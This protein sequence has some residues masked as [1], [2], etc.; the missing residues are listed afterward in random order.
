MGVVVAFDYDAW[1]ARYPEFTSVTEPVAE[2][3]FAEACVY[4]AN[5]G[6][7]PVNN[8][9]VQ[10]ALLGMLTAHIAARYQNQKANNPVG[11]ISSATEG[12]VTVNL[13]YNIPAGTAQWYNTT[14][15]GSDYWNATQVYRSFRYRAPTSSRTAWF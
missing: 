7:G 9:L 13:E 15:Y 8:S 6:S 3:Y 1:T 14:Q 2:L 5:D 4:H 10:T 11:R 12:S